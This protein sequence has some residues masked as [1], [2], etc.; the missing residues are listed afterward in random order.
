MKNYETA[1]PEGYKEIFHIDAKNKKTGLIFNLVALIPLVTVLAIVIPTA[2]V[3][4]MLASFADMEYI[5]YLL[6]VFVPLLVFIVALIAYLVLHELTHGAVYKA[7][8]KQKLSF[9]LSWSCA[10]C[11][12]P[13]IYVYRKTAIAALIAPFALFTV[14]LVPVT[15]LLA[16]VDPLWYILSGFILGL[17]IGGCSGDLYM[18]Y[19][20]L[21]KYKA[22]TLLVRDTGPEQWLYMLEK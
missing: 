19:L 9:G 20:L 22:K 2:G 12:V 17:H 8:T 11:G 6:K 1:L 3:S 14:I 7:L 18:L 13:N 10:F 4:E 5:Q 16:Y 21:F 15:V